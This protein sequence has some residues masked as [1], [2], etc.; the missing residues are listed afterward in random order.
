M[1][2][3]LNTVKSTIKKVT[4]YDKLVWQEVIMDALRG[5]H[6]MC[7]RCDN[8]GDCKIAKKLYKICIKDNVAIVITRCP[9]WKPNAA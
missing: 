7:L 9:D 8:L 5:S 3:T 4:K 1:L 2:H 6:C